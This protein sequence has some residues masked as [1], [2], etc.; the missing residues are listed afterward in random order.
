L[1]GWTSFFTFH[2]EWMIG[3]NNSFYS[4]YQGQLY[5]H[6]DNT[7]NRNTFYGVYGNSTITNVFNDKPLDAKMFKTIGLEGTQPWEATIT[8]DLGS[9]KIETAWF[10]KKEGDY[11]ANI[12]RNDAQ[13]D[14][15]MMSAQGIGDVNTV[16]V[17]GL[18]TFTFTINSLVNVGDVAYKNTTATSDKIGVI[19]AKTATSI[20]IGSVVNPPSPGDFILVIKNSVAESY[21]TRGYYMEVELVNSLTTQVELFSISSEAFKSYP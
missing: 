11:Y 21:G 4:M 15:D 18:L 7:V 9:G 14:L 1:Q 12:R 6:R 2:P 13:T 19:T 16:S 20:T 8:T 3:L 5:R 17:G 10:V